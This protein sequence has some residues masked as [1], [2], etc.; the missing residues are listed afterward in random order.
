MFICKP[1]GKIVQGKYIIIHK[2][3][4]TV[5]SNANIHRT[6]FVADVGYLDFGFAGTQVEVQTPVEAL[7]DEA[8]VGG[9]QTETG[10]LLGQEVHPSV[11][12][13]HV[14]PFLFLQTDGQTLQY[15]GLLLLYFS[16]IFLHLWTIS[17]IVNSPRHGHPHKNIVP[18]TVLLLFWPVYNYLTNNWGKIKQ[19]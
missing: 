8:S 10:V 14:L 7:V 5:Q 16:P 3:S 11:L 2:T 17:P 15:T 19:G 12:R 18:V 13:L 9:H 4:S 1:K 6:N